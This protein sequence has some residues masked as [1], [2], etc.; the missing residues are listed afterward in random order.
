MRTL[1]SEVNALRIHTAIC[2]GFNLITQSVDPSNRWLRWLHWLRSTTVRDYSTTA[3]WGT[4]GS[5]LSSAPIP[6][7]PQDASQTDIFKRTVVSA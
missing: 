3:L 6:C 4:E 7:K 5:N 1:W 2:D